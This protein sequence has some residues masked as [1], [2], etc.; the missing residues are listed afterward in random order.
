[1]LLDT[2]YPGFHF[3][4]MWGADDALRYALD[5]RQPARFDRD[6]KPAADSHRVV[7]LRWRG[8]PLDDAAEFLVVT[9]NYRA[10]GGGHFP[11]LGADK[12]VVDA[13]DETREALAHYLAA[14]PGGS[15]APTAAGAATA[16][17]ILPVDGVKLRF[18][19]GATAVRHVGQGSPVKWVKDNGDGSALFELAP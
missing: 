18:L 7:D 10:F 13:P 5:L 9:N 14:A 1:M 4:M 11:A 15:T 2:A 19:S 17:R 6:G 16:W 8:Q 12:V 3:D